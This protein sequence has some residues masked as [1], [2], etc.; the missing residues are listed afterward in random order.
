MAHA[1]RT[2]RA[3]K[4]HPF[5]S[6]CAAG[7]RSVFAGVW[8]IFPGCDQRRLLPGRLYGEGHSAAL[9]GLAVLPRKL[10]D[11]ATVRCGLH[12]RAGRSQR[13]LH[14][15][16]PAGRSIA[17]ADGCGVGRDL[18]IFWMVY[19]S[20]LCAAGRFRCAALR[21]VR[22]RS[23]CPVVGRFAF[24]HKPG[25]S[26]TGLPA[27]LAGGTVSDFGG[28]LLLFQAAPRGT[29]CF[30]RVVRAESCGHRDSPLLST[31]DLRCYAGA[32]AGTRTAHP[33]LGQTGSLSGSGSGMHP[34]VGLVSWTVLR[35]G[36]QRWAG[37]VWVFLDEPQRT[38]ESGGGKRCV[39]QPA[40]SGA[41]SG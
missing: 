2:G 40:P 18:P 3:P 24:C 31:D 41:E 39:L 38:V 7:D 29:V 34:G 14:R 23:G 37:A 28:A 22:Q 35:H 11:V 15:F 27:Y 20:V 26:G 21:V 4:P 8:G 17:S 12:Q 33:T 9:R 1:C 30:C 32:A 25:P 36:V 16:Y 19:P 10:H 6:R 13:R 5:C